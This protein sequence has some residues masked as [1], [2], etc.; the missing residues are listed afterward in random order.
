MPPNERRSELVRLDREQVAAAIAAVL[1]TANVNKA[2]V[3]E[4][5]RA[6]TSYFVETDRSIYV[7]RVYARKPETCAKERALL[8]FIGTRLPVPMILGTG[9]FANG[10]P[11]AVVEH[12]PGVHLAE[13]LK[14]AEP[15]LREAARELGR[16]LA[17]LTQIRFADFGDLNA[18]AAGAL[19]T[20]PWGF[21]DFHRWCLFESPAGARLG[22]LRD[23]L[24]AVLQETRDRFEDPF[25]IHLTH[26]DFN[27]DNLLFHD[28]G[29]L[30]AVLD[31][32][33]AHAGKLWLD[34]GNL[35][36]A[37]PELTLEAELERELALGFAERGQRLPDDFRAHA[38]LE[39][40]GS[41]LDFL[42]SPEDKPEIHA[43]ARAQIEQLLARFAR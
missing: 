23:R 6:N 2:R 11:Y 28:D 10:L 1:P 42:S 15:P 12:V 13:L 38:E 5:G 30:A 17:Q 39:D 14:R 20:V 32:E 19:V 8:T 25:A 4:L 22:A 24:W 33:F 31:W 18:D 9:Q 43:R 40:V 21:S 37:R 27:P 34:L 26:G 29:R 16:T 3:S 36:R 41:A 35:L 7:L